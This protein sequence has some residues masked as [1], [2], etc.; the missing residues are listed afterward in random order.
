MAMS[1]GIVFS[2]AF[3]NATGVA[4]TKYASAAQ[5]STVDTSRTLVIWMVNLAIG[6]ETFIFGQLIG[7]IILV[8]AT[9][10][11][12][13]ILIL[14]IECLNRNTR[15]MQEKNSQSRESMAYVA[16]SPT[17]LKYDSNRNKRNI[18]NA[19]AS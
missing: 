17:G 5:R 16:T 8:F 7:F 14:P 11:Y 3:F 12:N 4:I 19:R 18:E 9:L 10:V 2:I 6:S 15:A 1:I 13:E